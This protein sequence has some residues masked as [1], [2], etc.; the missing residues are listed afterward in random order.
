MDML[1][2]AVSKTHAMRN[3]VLNLRMCVSAGVTEGLVIILIVSPSVKTTPKIITPREMGQFKKKP[4]YKLGWFMLSKFKP[5]AMHV[6]GEA[7]GH[8]RVDTTI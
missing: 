5:I 6:E 1:R 2:P 3:G 7:P 8:V 4:E